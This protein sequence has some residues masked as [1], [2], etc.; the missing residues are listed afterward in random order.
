M[1]QGSNN[2]S[3]LFPVKASAFERCLLGAAD[4][5]ELFHSGEYALRRD[6]SV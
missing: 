1:D 3:G 2:G 6:G 5:V 4:P